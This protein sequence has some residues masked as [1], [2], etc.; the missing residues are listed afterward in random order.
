MFFYEEC[1]Q[2]V[3]IRDEKQID[4]APFLSASTSKPDFVGHLLPS[5]RGGLEKKR[6]M[7]EQ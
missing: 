3:I 7:E 6:W 5:S 1:L 2:L 4:G